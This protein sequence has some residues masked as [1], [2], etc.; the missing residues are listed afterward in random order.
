[1]TLIDVFNATMRVIKEHGLSSEAQ[2]FLLQ[3]IAKNN[4]L[5]NPGKVTMTDA[6]MRAEAKLSKGGVTSVKSTLK[7]LGLI[8]YQGSKQQATEY[9]LKYLRGKKGATQVV[10]H[11]VGH[12]IGHAVG[13]AVGQ[14][15]STAKLS[16]S[17]KEERDAGAQKA[18]EAL[19]AL[20][21]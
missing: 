3:L 11:T 15:S 10:G 20:D 8:E 16:I 12:A 6:E 1:M 7:A 14:S 21:W 5:G 9:E 19:E 18:L 4:R 13:H 17:K 2:V